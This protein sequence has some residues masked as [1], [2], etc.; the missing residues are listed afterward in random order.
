MTGE[1]IKIGKLV[2]FQPRDSLLDPSVQP[3]LPCYKRRL[4]T[5]A[6]LPG[7]ASFG[8]RC[9]RVLRMLANVGGPH[10]LVGSLQ[11][12]IYSSH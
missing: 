3:S 7:T 12:S 2:R 8:R 10:A 9:T 6:N 5:R 1:V 11:R 4:D